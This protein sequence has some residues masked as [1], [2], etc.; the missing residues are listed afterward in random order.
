MRSS[1]RRA[2]RLVPILAVAGMWPVGGLAEDASEDYPVW[3]DRRRISGVLFAGYDNAAGRFGSAGFKRRVRGS[4]DQTGTTLMTTLGFGED[5]QRDR[6]SPNGRKR[7]LTLQT[8]NFVGFQYVGANAG[9]AVHIGT[10]TIASEERPSFHQRVNAGFAAAMD[11]W[12]KPS[13]GVFTEISVVAGS[14]RES[15]WARGAA[16][17][18]LPSG[19][20]V[21][22]KAHWGPEMIL[23]VDEQSRFGRLGLHVGPLT[24][25]RLHLSTSVGW[26]VPDDGRHGL[27][28]TLG[29]YAKF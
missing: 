4:I 10:E 2:S 7:T 19:M 20:S 9:W 3:Q 29:G 23:Y 8:R 25:W 16:G 6:F 13:P 11:F 12:G 24:L 28:W 15:I 17:Y 27:Y 21:L 18:A 1:L 14:A 26:H 22:R 5:I